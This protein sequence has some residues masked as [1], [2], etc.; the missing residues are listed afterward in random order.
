MGGKNKLATQVFD[1]VVLW[2]CVCVCVD[3]CSVLSF[4]YLS[5]RIDRVS[6]KTKEP[7]VPRKGVV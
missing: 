5:I 3:V 7:R 2:A 6:Q 1:F 4:T